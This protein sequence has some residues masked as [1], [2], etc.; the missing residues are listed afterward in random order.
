MEA[1]STDQKTFQLVDNGKQL[2]EIIYKS[3]FSFSAE[4]KLATSDVY[5]IKSVGFFGTSIA[6]TRGGADI[7][8]LNMN[9][10]G[11]IVIAFQSGQE[12]V[13][14]A[15]GTF[16]NK[17]V[18]E[19]KDEKKIVLFDPTFNW[20]KWH[21]NYTITYDEKPQDILL[22]LLGVYASNY[23]IATMSGMA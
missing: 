19:D 6:V 11:Q 21:Y 17:F 2:G 15:I 23:F 18:I 10:R 22:V 5:E 14:K 9:W 16:Y 20:S 3:I 1:N 7:A 13:L 8:T 12:F 4:I